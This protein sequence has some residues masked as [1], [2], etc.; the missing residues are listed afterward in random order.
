M[1]HAYSDASQPPLSTVHGR[2]PCLLPLGFPSLHV[3]SKGPV[4][5]EDD[6]CQ[7]TFATTCSSS[8]RSLHLTRR[9]APFRTVLIG[10]PRP[11]IAIAARL[12]RRPW[13]ATTA[14][15]RHKWSR[16]A[17]C[18]RAPRARRRLNARSPWR[19]WPVILSLGRR[20]DFFFA[21]RV[22]RA[23]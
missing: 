22:T 15:Q 3:V 11:G 6:S 19:S 10:E 8:P 7:A 12:G 17:I 14:P 4:F 5:S 23:A 9:I 1:S 16:F 18:G 2:R 13:R 21:A 20:P